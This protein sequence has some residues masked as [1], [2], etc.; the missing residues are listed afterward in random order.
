MAQ[1]LVRKLCVHCK[2]VQPVFPKDIVPPKKVKQHHQAKG[3]NSCYH[4]GYAGRIALYELLPLTP[5]LK[6]AF[7]SAP[8]DEA[9]Y[10]RTQAHASL[11]EQAWKLIQT[12]VTSLEEVYS[13]VAL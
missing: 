1:R 11:K 9:A 13:F 6:T 10:R 7:I 5:A 12:G 3:C 8:N 2:E 4:T